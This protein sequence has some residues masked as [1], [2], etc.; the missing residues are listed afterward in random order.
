MTRRYDSRA[1]FAAAVT[2]HLCFE[3][4]LVAIAAGLVIPI[5]FQL[6]FSLWNDVLAATT[7][8]LLGII[9]VI[10]NAQRVLR[11]FAR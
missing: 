9:I 8:L 4:V 11:L 10:V 1:R 7:I 5:G 2:K 6:G 3:A